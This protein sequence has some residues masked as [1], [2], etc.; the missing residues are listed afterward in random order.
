[1]KYEKPEVA[2]LGTALGTIQGCTKGATGTDSNQSCG[3]NDHVLISAY[4]ADE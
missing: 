4:E 1:M 2:V 3:N